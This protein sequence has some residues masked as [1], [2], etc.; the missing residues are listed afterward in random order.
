MGVAVSVFVLVS[1]CVSVMLV[2]TNNSEPVRVSGRAVNT[3][4]SHIGQAADVLYAAQTTGG[5]VSRL[6][7][8][9]GGGLALVRLARVALRHGL[10][11]VQTA[12]GLRARESGMAVTHWD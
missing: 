9:G 1:F 12:L 7:T 6:T 5:R 10:P 4:Y 11:Q 3:F 8:A 2:T